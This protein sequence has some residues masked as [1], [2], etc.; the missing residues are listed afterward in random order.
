M[1][2]FVPGKNPGEQQGIIIPIA[3]SGTM[4]GIDMEMVDCTNFVICCPLGV[5]TAWSD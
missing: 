3:I 4:S 1:N 2:I 5:A